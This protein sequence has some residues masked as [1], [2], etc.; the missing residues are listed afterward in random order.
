MKKILAAMALAACPLLPAMSQTLTLD[1]CAARAREHYPLVAQYGILEEISRLDLAEVAKAWLPQGSI[2]GRVTWQNDVA[3]FPEAL[4]RIL[5]QTGAHYPGM[6]KTQYQAGVEITQTIWDGGRITA[7][8]KALLSQVAVRK[9][10]VDA[11]LYEVEGRVEEIYF[12]ILLLDGRM[13]R[14]DRSIALVDSTLSQ[15]RSM[16]AHGV[17]MKSDCDQIE[18]RLLALRQQ[19]SNLESGRASLGRILE[20]FIGEPL[21]GRSLVLPAA[22]AAPRGAHPCLREFDTRIADVEARERSVNASVMPSVGAFAT[23]F[24]GYPGYNMFKN[25][26]SRD[27]SFN[28]MVGVTASWNF[29]ALYSRKT[30]LD[31]LKWQR[32]AIATEKEAFEFNNRVAADECTGR[33]EALKEIMAYDERILEL[34]RSVMQAARSRLRNGVID[35]TALLAKITDEELAENDLILHRI[36]LVKAIYNL[37]HLRNK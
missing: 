21:G 2:S 26:Q 25:M 8:R 7:G 16:F 3:A 14:C 5:A 37:N 33:I 4:T 23:G 20:I 27:P 6:D 13:A 24:Y 15:V 1:E 18:A 12:S 34:R 22:D 36:E 28:F 9:A 30:L 35:A 19:R 17:A 31:K 29:S 10:A 11:G 32:R